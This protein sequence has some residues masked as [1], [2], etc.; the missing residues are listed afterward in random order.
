MYK[1]GFKEAEEP[2]IKLPALIG[3][4]KKQGNS[5]LPPKKS[6]SLTVL[7]PLTVWIKI[8]QK[9]LKE[10]G[11]PDHVA[12]LLRNLYAVQE[13]TVRTR[14]GTADLF[15]VGK[16]VQQG[17]MLFPCLFNFYS[18]YVMRNARMDKSQSGIKIVG[19]NTNNL[20]YADDTTLMT[21]SEELESLLMSVKEKENL[22]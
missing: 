17:Y 7:M 1:L 16:E 15:Q 18:E 11:I 4:W 13:A 21:E 8:N 14:H 19:R 5:P 2:E 9:I 22:I 6:A 10:V 20:K 12:C 3:S